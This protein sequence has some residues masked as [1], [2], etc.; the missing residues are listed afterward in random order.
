VSV[1][2]IEK[3][4]ET[5]FGHVVSSISLRHLFQAKCSRATFR[6]LCSSNPIAF[7]A[8]PFVEVIREFLIAEQATSCCLV[9]LSRTHTMTNSH[10][11][12]IF[13]EPQVTSVEYD[14]HLRSGGPLQAGSLVWIAMV[15]RR[16]AAAGVFIAKKNNDCGCSCVRSGSAA[17][18]FCLTAQKFTC[19]TNQQV[20]SPRHCR[21]LPIQ[22]PDT[23]MAEGIEQAIWQREIAAKCTLKHS[24]RTS[25]PLLTLGSV[26]GHIPYRA[27]GDI[28]ASLSVIPKLPFGVTASIF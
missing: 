10:D 1:D 13:L 7:F 9:N 20:D 19:R 28:I 6:S 16:T 24:S 23:K 26:S 15:A 18:K 12:A 22:Q 3:A 21:S 2:L 11:A 8:P 17:E 25:A 5:A 4:R 27:I 14:A